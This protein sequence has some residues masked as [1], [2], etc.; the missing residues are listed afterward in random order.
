MD[1]K[2]PR[3]WERDPNEFK[4]PDIK[5]WVIENRGQLLAALLTM[6]R[7]WVEAG[8]PSGNGKILGSF[9]EWCRTLGGILSHAG[10]TGFLDNSEILYS[11]TDEEYD[12]W[13]RFFEI[14]HSILGEKKVEAKEVVMQLDNADQDFSLEAPLAISEAMSGNRRGRIIR[15]ALALGKKDRVKYANGFM[16][17][18]GKDKAEKKKLW[19][20]KKIEVAAGG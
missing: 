16:F 10:V 19:Q 14:W 17:V 7:A 18:K 8:R 4:H 11:E 2:V 5:G 6:A 13:Q 12:Q 9:E 1:A 20:V 15:V 3:P